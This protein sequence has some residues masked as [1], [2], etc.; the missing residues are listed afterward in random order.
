MHLGCILAMHGEP[1]LVIY[2][3]I[4]SI[5][6]GASYDDTC[7]LGPDDHQFLDYESYVAY[8]DIDERRL[9]FIQRQIDS[10]KFVPKE[11]F[12]PGVVERII[13]GAIDSKD[14]KPFVKRVLKSL[15]SG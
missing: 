3:T 8:W 14:S 13:Q 2:V 7:V 10:G 11:D 9:T 5:E 1:T 12:A 4:T 15:R 6:E